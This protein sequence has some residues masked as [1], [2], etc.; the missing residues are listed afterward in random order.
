MISIIRWSRTK[1][2]LEYAMIQNK[3]TWL[4]TVLAIQIMRLKLEFIWILIDYTLY[5]SW[6]RNGYILNFDDLS[7]MVLTRPCI[8]KNTQNTTRSTLSISHFFK[9]SK[10]KIMLPN[11]IVW[12][13]MKKLD[14]RLLRV[15]DNFQCLFFLNIFIKSSVLIKN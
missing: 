4:L 6:S 13:S 12:Q 2:M 9:Y 10:T 14:F 11:G 5:P 1:L 15:F 7:N 3:A 8:K